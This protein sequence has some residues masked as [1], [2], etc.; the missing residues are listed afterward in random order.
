MVTMDTARFQ[1]PTRMDGRIYVAFVNKC[2]TENR[3]IRETLER[4]ISFY[5][6]NG[7]DMFAFSKVKKKK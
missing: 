2:R 3:Q 6:K 7:E 5:I 4:L 1:R